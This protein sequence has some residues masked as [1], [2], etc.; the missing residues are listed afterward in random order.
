MDWGAERRGGI[1]TCELGASGDRRRRRATYVVGLHLMAISS[2]PVPGKAMV[3][4][5]CPSVVVV[6]CGREERWRR[7][8]RG[9]SSERAG[10]KKREKVSHLA[11][12]FFLFFSN[13]RRGITSKSEV[14]CAS[15]PTNPAASSKNIQN[16]CS[17]GWFPSSPRRRLDHGEP[18]VHLHDPPRL[19]VPLPRHL[20]PP[21]PDPSLPAQQSFARA[22]HSALEGANPK[23]KR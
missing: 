14:V 16:V 5:I 7:E 11:S 8:E 10:S 1:R 13:H 23:T 4:A 2:V 12:L 18:A 15:Q 3:R 9:V 19:A 22:G 6:G 20:R 21:S 17:A